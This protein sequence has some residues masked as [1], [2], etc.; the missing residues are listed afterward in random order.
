M[1]KSGYASGDSNDDAVTVLYTKGCLRYVLLIQ[2]EHGRWVY[3]GALAG[4]PLFCSGLTL[5]LPLISCAGPIV[6]RICDQ[7]VILGWTPT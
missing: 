3:A 7:W 1:V 2:G 6:C 4:A 5:T